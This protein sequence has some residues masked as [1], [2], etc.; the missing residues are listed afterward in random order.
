MDRGGINRRNPRNWTSS[1]GSPDRPR[2]AGGGR[3]SLEITTPSR[4]VSLPPSRVLSPAPPTSLYASMHPFVFVAV[5]Y[6]IYIY[7][8]PY[9]LQSLDRI[10]QLKFIYSK[11]FVRIVF[12]RELLLLPSKYSLVAANPKNRV[13]RPASNSTNSFSS[14]IFLT[15]RSF[16][17]PFDIYREFV[18]MDR[19]SNEIERRKRRD[20]GK[21]RWK[22]HLEETRKIIH[23]PTT[24]QKMLLF[25]SSFDFSIL[26]SISRPRFLAEQRGF[27]RR[28]KLTLELFASLLS[29]PRF[30]FLVFPSLP[31]TRFPRIPPGLEISSIV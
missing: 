12:E 4:D 18:S 26:F 1:N 6:T 9:P 10:I 5:L 19:W 23:P 3:D 20:R 30:E 29:R 15:R 8:S 25:R 28:N 22:R 11:C 24:R 31:P 16:V 17:P 2:G 14:S 21:R 13:S 7:L 27:F